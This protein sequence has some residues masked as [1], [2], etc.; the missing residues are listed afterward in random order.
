MAMQLPVQN[1][2]RHHGDRLR[3][4]GQGYGRL[5]DGGRRDRVEESVLAGVIVAGDAHGGQL[6]GG[7]GSLSDSGKGG[8]QHDGGGQCRIGIQGH[9]RT[10][11]AGEAVGM[12]ARRHA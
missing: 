12:H 3:R 9:G 10:A 11:G 1:R 7:I 4:L 8:G 2:S 5:V 6:H